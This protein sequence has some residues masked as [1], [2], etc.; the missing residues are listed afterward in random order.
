MD[1]SIMPT[2]PATNTNLPT[3]MVTERCSVWLAEA[4]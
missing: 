4:G 3:L 1:A 2:I